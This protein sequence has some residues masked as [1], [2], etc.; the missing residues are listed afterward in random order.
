MISRTGSSKGVRGFTLIELL[1][2]IAIVSITLGLVTPVFRKTFSDI[3]LKTC[4]QDMVSLI[5]YAKEHAI[6]KNTTLRF[7][8]DTKEGSYWL[9]KKEQDKDVFRRLSGNLGRRY[10][11]P[12]GLQIE[13]KENYIDFYP[14]GELTQ[15]EIRITNPN[16]KSLTIFLKPNI[17]NNIAVSENEE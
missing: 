8:L 4:V 17:G 6:V 11:S 13:T 5:R 10:I 3:Q 9:T 14:D 7:N 16:K 15:A 2:V 1:V 12:S